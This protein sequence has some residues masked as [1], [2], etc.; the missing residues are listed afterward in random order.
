MKPQWTTP[1]IEE[2]NLCDN[3][4]GAPDGGH[5]NDSFCIYT[6]EDI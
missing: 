6:L 4:D 5:V 2:R 1:T 3:C